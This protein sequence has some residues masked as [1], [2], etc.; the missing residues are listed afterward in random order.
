MLLAGYVAASVGLLFLTL[1]VILAPVILPSGEL[2]AGFGGFG[3]L[4][5]PLDFGISLV[6]LL[7]A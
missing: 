1:H 4:V 3:S 5:G 2:I 6:S 7:S